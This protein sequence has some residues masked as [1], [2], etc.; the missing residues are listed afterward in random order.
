LPEVAPIS[1]S[2]RDQ[3]ADVSP[4]AA[5]AGDAAGIGAALAVARRPELL[6][7]RSMPDGVK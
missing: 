1:L 3:P 2:S 5:V 6:Y 4:R 7:N